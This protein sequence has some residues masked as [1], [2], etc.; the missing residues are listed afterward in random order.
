MGTN[1]ISGIMAIIMMLTAV[2]GSFGQAKV[3]QPVSVEVSVG[4]DGDIPEGMISGTTP[5]M[6]AGIVELINI[7]SV[8]FSAD[9]T[10]SKL[11]ISL[12]DTPVASL[13]VKENGDVW[14][15]VSDL[16]PGTVL[17]LTKQEADALTQQLFSSVIPAAATSAQSSLTDLLAKFEFEAIVPVID[18]KI[19]ELSA[20]FEG[21]FSEFED[22]E[23]LVGEKT[24]TKK[25]VLNMTSKEAATLLVG[26]VKDILANEAVTVL[27]ASL[28]GIIDVKSIDETLTN[29]ANTPDE[30][31][32][33]LSVAKYQDPAGDSCVAVVVSKKD[34]MDVYVTVAET[35]AET[36]VD[37]SL[38]AGDQG[39][40]TASVVMDKA[41]G[42]AAFSLDVVT[43]QTTMSMAGSV[44]AVEGGVGVLFELTLPIPGAEEPITFSL[45]VSVTNGAPTVTVPADAEVIAISEM[46]QSEELAQTFNSKIMVGMMTVLGNVMTATANMPEV[47]AIFASLLSGMM[48]GTQTTT[49]AN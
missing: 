48:P 32:P 20:A 4:L 39:G 13:G 47:Q 14:Q 16:F 36:D 25:S 15:A 31:A 9:T 10:A 44:I 34:Q 45:A 23:Y 3:A 12:A 37:L 26:A 43:P 11:Q 7:L 41:T 5:E 35:A 24:Y 19:N 2:C 18:A 33:E 40:A 22:G 46:Q 28:G 21:K 8:G 6:A 30:D 38:V 17:T 1:L 42:E 27:I 49:P 29:I